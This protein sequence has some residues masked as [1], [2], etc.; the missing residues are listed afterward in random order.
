MPIFMFG[1]RAALRLIET[2]R[3]GDTAVPANHEIFSTQL[4]IRSSCGSAHTMMEAAGG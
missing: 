3:G 1:E 4:V 2:L